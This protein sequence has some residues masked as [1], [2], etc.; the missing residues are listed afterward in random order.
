MT[1]PIK[2]QDHTFIMHPSGVLFWEEK[3]ML[4]ISDVHLGKVSHFR[5]FGAAVPQKAVLKNFELMN[6]AIAFF[7]P[8]TICFLGDLF[9]S[10]VNK[11]WEL[12][13]K[14]VAQTSS[15][16][17]L[18]EGNH[19]IISPL[20]YEKLGVQVV[21]EIESN[22]FL[23]THHPEERKGYFNF[24]GHIHPAVRLRGAGR[25][26]LRLPCFF[27]SSNQMIVPAFGEFTGNHTLKPSKKNEVFA[28]TKESVFQV[29]LG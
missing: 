10:S 12:F 15:E 18:V 11:E 3:S 22:G 21:P 29:D 19:D 24:S 26:T 1:L 8:K 27:K 9:H 25:Q 14:W 7:Y 28:V 20:K 16:L 13:E 17:I 2:I 23:F 6:E 5:K 4:I